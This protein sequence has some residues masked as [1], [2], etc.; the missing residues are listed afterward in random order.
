MTESTKRDPI[1]EWSGYTKQVIAAALYVPGVL[2]SPAMQ[3]LRP[4]DF[5]DEGARRLWP[6]IKAMPY[7]DGIVD[8]VELKARFPDALSY[9]TD[10]GHGEAPAPTL[11][12][13]VIRQL[14]NLAATRTS[15]MHGKAIAEASDAG[16][17]E[18]VRKLLAGSAHLL[19]RDSTDRLAVVSV[20]AALD[21][22]AWSEKPETFAARHAHTGAEGEP[23]GPVDVLFKGTASMLAAAGG[24]GKSTF[25][26]TLA[27][28]VAAS[29][30]APDD[31]VWHAEAF[32]DP[33]DG[34][35]CLGVGSRAE[36]ALVLLG[37]D[38]RSITLQRLRRIT[39]RIIRAEDEHGRRR[40]ATTAEILE[41]YGDRLHLAAYN[42]SAW[43]AVGPDR[44]PSAQA[45]GLVRLARSL[46]V[47]FIFVDPAARFMQEGAEIDAREGTAFVAVWQELARDTG[48]HVMVAHH[49][50]QTSRS[51]GIAAAY[52]ARGTTALTDGFRSVLMMQP[53]GDPGEGER[54]KGIT[55]RLVKTNFA[56]P[57][58]PMRLTTQHGGVPRVETER[59]RIDRHKREHVDRVDAMLKRLSDA[60]STNDTWSVIKALEALRALMKGT[61]KGAVV[62]LYA[63]AGGERIDKL[64]AA[65]SDPGGDRSAPKPK[66][67]EPRVELDF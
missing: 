61:N 32:G 17:L 62:G 20:A 37:E 43:Q 52:A 50:N 59:E 47:D 1:K 10:R 55:L 3:E 22:P 7:D 41:T 66:K 12:P 30:R 40:D 29:V 15:A 49:T 2:D 42:G 39:G 16:D 19:E 34:G 58:P 45:R 21:D 67:S 11:L 8:L 46:D 57:M 28:H 14:R 38:P 64:S 18:R 27:A 4:G 65:L 5:A 6:A 44:R 36:R 33:A 51:E 23:D 31:A 56:P 35:W 9:A 48:A 53:D 54:H 13:S 60:E 25:G 63:A 24:V 26:L